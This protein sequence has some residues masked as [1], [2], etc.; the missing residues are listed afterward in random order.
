M[1]KDQGNLL[2][3]PFKYVNNFFFY[4]HLLVVFFPWVMSKCCSD[5]QNF[6]LC[7][8]SI[9]AIY[10]ETRIRQQRDKCMVLL[11]MTSSNVSSLFS[12]HYFFLF[13]E[14]CLIVPFVPRFGNISTHNFTLGHQLHTQHNSHESQC[15]CKYLITEKGSFEVKWDFF[16]YHISSACGS[17]ID[18]SQQQSTESVKL[19]IFISDIHSAFRL[20]SLRSF[21]SFFSLSN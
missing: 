4:H 19:I 18:V 5:F 3:F 15:L 7:P 8:S 1:H 13:I 21:L 9:V 6:P 11:F 20:H 12:L 2:S 17:P 14:I 16:S 10:K